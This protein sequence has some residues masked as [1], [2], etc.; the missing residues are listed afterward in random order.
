MK[1]KNLKNERVVS[2]VYIDRTCSEILV[3]FHLIVNY[4]RKIDN[5]SKKLWRMRATFLL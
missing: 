2:T 4:S 3:N 1:K 5:F